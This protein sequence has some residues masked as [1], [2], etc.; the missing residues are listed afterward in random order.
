MLA[1]LLLHVE[2]AAVE[3][4]EEDRLEVLQDAPSAEMVEAV[5]RAVATALCRIDVNSSSSLT[6]LRHCPIK[7][8]G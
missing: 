2:G 7:L 4:L 8:A 1:A 3:L 6:A 5:R